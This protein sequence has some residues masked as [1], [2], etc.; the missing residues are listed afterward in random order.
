M[1][2]ECALKKPKFN[3]IDLFKSKERVKN[4]IQLKKSII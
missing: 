3:K 1:D 4:N 2:I